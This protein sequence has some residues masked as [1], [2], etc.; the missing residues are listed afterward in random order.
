M[1]GHG[2]HA[3]EAVTRRVQ[4]AICDYGA[5]FQVLDAD[6]QDAAIL[7]HDRTS[8]E[9]YRIRL[10]FL[11]PAPTPEA[12]KR[13]YQERIYTNAAVYPATVKVEPVSPLYELLKSQARTIMEESPVG[14]LT[15]APDSVESEMTR[16]RSLALAGEP[17]VGSI[18]DAV[19]DPVIRGF[20]PV[21]LTGI[22]DRAAMPAPRDL[23]TP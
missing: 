10:E 4:H 7:I 20:R 11:Q 12:A 18:R 6:Y 22:G 16:W 13:L 14:D 8:G 17:Y 3:E 1:S 2:N 9:L 5:G 21:V 15:S 19:V 23:V